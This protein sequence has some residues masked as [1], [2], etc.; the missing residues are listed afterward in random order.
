[1]ADDEQREAI[2]GAVARE[3]RKLYFRLA[4]GRAVFH[5]AWWLAL[6]H[7]LP[8]GLSFV[9]QLL[10]TSRGRLRAVQADFDYGPITNRLMDVDPSW[11]GYA[12]IAMAALT[13]LVWLWTGGASWGFS[14]LGVLYLC[15]VGGLAVLAWYLG[16]Q[17]Y[18]AIDQAARSAIEAVSGAGPAPPG[19]GVALF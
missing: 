19:T 4:A 8:R 14:L 13:L 15:G 5:T 11:W 10:Q 18:Q 9:V 7:A 2:R 3:R 6:A 16:W 12:A 1:M 17:P